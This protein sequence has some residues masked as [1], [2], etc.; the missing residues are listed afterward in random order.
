M[1]KKACFENKFIISF[2]VIL[3]RKKQAMNFNKRVDLEQRLD[4]W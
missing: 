2:D 3:L 1:N 4:Y